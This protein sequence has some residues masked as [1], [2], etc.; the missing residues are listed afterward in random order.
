MPDIT[1]NRHGDRWAVLVLVRPD[2]E[3]G[4]GNASPTHRV[5]ADRFATVEVMFATTVAGFTL[6]ELADF[7]TRCRRRP[8]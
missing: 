7:I 2:P 1:V 6:E 4:S 3:P 5:A 8:R